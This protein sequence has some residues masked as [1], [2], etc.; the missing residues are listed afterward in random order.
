MAQNYR[1]ETC[2]HPSGIEKRNESEI[3]QASHTFHDKH[4]PVS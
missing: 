4:G 1:G 2:R 3:L